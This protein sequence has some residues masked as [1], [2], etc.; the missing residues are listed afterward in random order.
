MGER[1]TRLKTIRL[2]ESLER[3]LVKE[4][5][6][7]GTTVNAYV[8]SVLSRHLN[9]DKK[10]EEFGIA[11]IPKSMLKSLLEGCNDETLARIGR[12]S[13]AV[14]KEMAEFFFQDSSP[15]GILNLLATRSRFNPKNQTRVTKE[16]DNYTI[17]MRHDFGPK[18]SIIVKNGLE[19]LVKQSFHAEPRISQGESV[20]TAR[21]KVN[22]RRLSAR[23]SAQS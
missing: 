4:A 2:S 8:N 22:P 7:E 19:G 11:E 13:Y 15:D 10:L 9:W 5:A 12:E 23:E 3:S 1:K 16:E 14:R 6:D 20:I 21:F 18:W 17:V